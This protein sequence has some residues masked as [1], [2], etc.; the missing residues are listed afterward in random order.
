MCEN[1]KD[2]FISGM[3]ETSAYLLHK[4]ST[5]LEKPSKVTFADLRKSKEHFLRPYWTS[6]SFVIFS[7]ALYSCL[8]PKFCSKL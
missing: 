2:I 3:G 4:S 5:A 1:M 8:S 7:F 6:L